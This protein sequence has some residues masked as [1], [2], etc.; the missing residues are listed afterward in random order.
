MSS[1]GKTSV[2][3]ICDGR[4]CEGPDHCW[5]NGTGECRHTTRAEHALH[6]DADIN[7]FMRI[8]NGDGT[9]LVEPYDG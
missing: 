4:A 1:S 7:E 9:I 6:K 2:L 5:H 3:Y 8:T